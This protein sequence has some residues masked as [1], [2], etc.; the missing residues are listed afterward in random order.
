[1]DTRIPG[2]PTQQE[3]KD[4]AEDARTFKQTGDYKKGGKV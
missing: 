3:I 2:A 4:T 1:M